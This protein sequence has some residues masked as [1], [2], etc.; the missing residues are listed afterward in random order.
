[1]S[2]TT[3]AP[4]SQTALALIESRLNTIERLLLDRVPRQDRLAIVQEV[5]SQIHHLLESRGS[6]NPTT[7]DVLAV[8][9]KLDPPEAYLGEASSTAGPA[10]AAAR[11]PRPSRTSPSASERPEAPGSEA[12]SRASGF[13]GLGG[14]LGLPL[15]AGLGFLLVSQGGSEVFAYAFLLVLA[16]L[17]GGAGSI[18]IGLA[19]ASRRAGVWSIVGA[20][21]SA[22]LLI[23]L[24]TSMAC[25]LLAG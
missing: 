5:E 8:L 1:M 9:A 21:S 16:L 11:R 3:S 18:G 6:E 19:I 2:S 25:L 12:L 10:Q 15:L 24:P 23:L 14:L 7:D 13:V 17:T 4:L 22:L 20:A